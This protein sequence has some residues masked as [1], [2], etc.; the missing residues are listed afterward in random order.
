MVEY[1]YVVVDDGQ[2][3]RQESFDKIEDALAYAKQGK[4]PFIFEYKVVEGELDPETEELV[5]T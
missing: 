3:L 2:A 4:L 5:W 1:K